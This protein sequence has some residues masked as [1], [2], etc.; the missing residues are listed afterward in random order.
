MT[1]VC[2]VD[3][4]GR[5]PVIGPMILAG[6]SIEEEKLASLKA[7]GVKDSKE[8]SANQRNILYEKIIKVVKGYKVLVVSPSEI[9][10][11][12]ESRTSNL[13]TLEAQKFA[14]I[15]NHLK[16]D[17]VI[18]DCPST[19]IRAY[20][21][22][23]KLYLKHDVNLRCE[24][25]ADRNWP[26]VAAASILAKVTRDR[27]VE[28]LKEKYKIEFGSGYPAD[29]TTKKFLEENWKKHAK[30]FR[31]SWATYKKYSDSAKQKS[32]AEF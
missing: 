27:E 8:L 14:M 6:V 26:S 24:H 20:S 19:N 2:G 12:V 30:I 16:P 23:L 9:D 10:T 13:N 17:I 4:A 32:L 22:T 18:V 11:A 25:K 5:G 31:K 29:P 15:I 21:E 1:V 7:L 28:A 3:D